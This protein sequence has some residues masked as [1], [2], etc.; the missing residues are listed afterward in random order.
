MLKDFIATEV[1]LPKD[2]TDSFCRSGILQLKVL[3]T[4]IK[5]TTHKNGNE[6]NVSFLFSYTSKLHHLKVH[7]LISSP[8]TNSPQMNIWLLTYPSKYFLVRI[9]AIRYVKLSH[10]FSSLTFPPLDQRK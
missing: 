4:K 9:R 6:E 8:P 7:L 2:S 1:L 10:L 3:G 5:K